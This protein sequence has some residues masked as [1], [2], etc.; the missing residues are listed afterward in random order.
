MASNSGGTSCVVIGAGPAGLTAA[1]ALT[2]SGYASVVLEADVVVG[3]IARTVERDGWRFDIGGHR[4]FTK[5]PIVEKLWQEILPAEHWLVR[6][7]LSRIYFNGKMFEYPLR[8]TDVFRKLG[9]IESVR[10]LG[11]YLAAQVRPPKD[12]SSF[13]GW[14]AARFGWRLYRTF[15]E[16]YTQKVWGVPPSEIQAD[17]AAQR[18]RNLSLMAVIRDALRPRRSTAR[19][20]A[21]SLIT[22]FHYPELGPGMLWERCRSLIEAEG[23]EVLLEHPVIRIRRDSVVGATHVV[24]KRPDGEIV[25]VACDHVVSSMPLGALVHA[26]DPPAPIEVRDAA[27]RLR[28]RDFL[29]VAIVVPAEAGFPDNWIYVHSPDVQVGRIQNFGSWS[30][31]MVREGTTCLGLEYFVNEGDALWGAADEDLVALATAELERLGLVRRDQVLAG[32]VVRMPKAYPIYDEGFQQAVSTVREWLAAEVPNTHP[33]GRNGMHKYN[34]QDH[35]ML[36]SLL[37]VDNIVADAGH[38]IWNV[39][40]D[41]EYHEDG[42]TTAG[43]GRDAPILPRPVP[44]RTT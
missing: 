37:T 39:N 16:T 21:T 35:S 1:L 31:Q 33:V 7:R 27:S 8:A 15:F 40:V 43:T 24:V 19:S 42:R 2:R 9:P 18:I 36:T 25:E 13:E 20:T 17:W 44:L 6:P 4:F 11:S 38:D 34:N 26:M 5:V 22:T 32:Y 30:P 10:C 3:G 23:G 29:T 41:G 14:V 12:Q 28:H